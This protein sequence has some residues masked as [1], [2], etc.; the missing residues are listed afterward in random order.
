MC[1]ENPAIAL[2][3]RAKAYKTCLPKSISSSADRSLPLSPHHLVDDA[4]VALDNL[5]DFRR[6]VFFDVVGHGNAVIAVLVHRDGGVDSLEQRLFVDAG[7]K[8]TCLVERFGAFGT[9][10][11]AHGRERVAHTREEGTFFGERAAVAHDGERVHLQAVVVMESERFVLNHSLVQLES[12]GGKAVTAARVATVQNRHI[13]LLGHLVDGGKEAREVRLGID[14]L[15]AVGAQQNVLA[16]LE[17]QTLMDIACLYCRQVL[18][19]DLSHGAAGY[20]S[21]FLG[22]ATIGQVAAGVFGIGHVYIAD[23]IDDAAVGLLG[24]ALVLAAVARFH[25]ENR[26]MQTLGRDGRETA[27]GIAQNEQGIG[28]AGG[29][30]LVATVDDIADG[31]AEVVTHGIHVDFGILEAKVLEEDSVQVVVVVLARVREDAVKVLT[32]LVDDGSK[33]DDF[34][35]GAYDNQEF[36]LAVVGKFHVG[37]IGLYIHSSTT[38]SPKVSGW[39]GSKDSLAHMT[40][41]RFSVSD[42]LIMLWV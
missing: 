32:A 42:K 18:V 3:P 20:V 41:T 37:V 29:H 9:G 10:T 23:D 38:F 13:V 12:A 2:R 25:V 6:D 31:S 35:A 26:D 36:Q 7:D 22:Q 5:H 28:L 30:E 24:Q 8:E 40:V 16:L 17:A 19:Q 27:V 33:A 1:T 21:A 34:G 39:F 14:I 4:G 15:F 11:D